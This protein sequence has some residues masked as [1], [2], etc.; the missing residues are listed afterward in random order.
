MCMYCGWF[1][2]LGLILG[3]IAF[4][5]GIWNY[6]RKHPE[7]KEAWEKYMLE[8]TKSNKWVKRILL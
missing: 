3:I 6:N 4:R 2:V 5:I 8:I 1:C 7:A